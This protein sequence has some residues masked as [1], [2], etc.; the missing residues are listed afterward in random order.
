MSPEPQPQPQRPGPSNAARGE[1]HHASRHL[2]DKGQE[3]GRWEG[4]VGGHKDRR[5]SEVAARWCGW[6][7][8]R[9]AA[10]LA[11]D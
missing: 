6:L 5:V 4:F 10:G 11:A 2:P 7:L 3:G 9:R 1:H 8:E